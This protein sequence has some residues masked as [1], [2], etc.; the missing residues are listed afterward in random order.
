MFVDSFRYTAV[1]R[2]PLSCSSCSIATPYD[3]KWG[4]STDLRNFSE[5]FLTDS[6]DD[7]FMSAGRIRELDGLRAVAIALVVAYHFDLHV[8]GGFLGVDLFFVVSG[9]VITR[10][11]LDSMRALNTGGAS[12]GG[13][14][15]R[16]L[17]KT[18]YVRRAWRLLPSLVIMLM[19]VTCA[20][21][22][23]GHGIDVRHT[24]DTALASL[25][26]GANWWIG[27]TATVHGV[28]PLT[29]T[30]SLA[31][32]EQLYLVLPM[33]LVIGRRRPRRAA[34]GLSLSLMGLSA[35]WFATTKLDPQSLNRAY[36]SSIARATPVAL[37]IALA[38]WHDRRQRPLA[39]SP[40]ILSAGWCACAA[41]TL[42]ALAQA[43]FD[44]TW[45]YQGGF[46]LMSFALAGLVALTVELAHSN[47]VIA[48]ILRS[49]PATFIGDRSYVLYLV[50][51]PLVFWFGSYGRIGSL[52]LRLVVAAV[53]SEALH[54]LVE[55]PL[56]LRGPHLRR[57]SFIASA[58]LIG[59]ALAVGA[60]LR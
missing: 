56:R 35:L 2:T 47:T 45:L 26:G 37:G 39:V 57:A 6:A 18:F 7:P 3:K 15:V 27:A 46:E 13:N 4:V 50:H 33:V 9:Y 29:H 5:R 42:P 22:V 58:Q 10:G 51:F 32:E 34:L 44:T 54:R 59:A 11:L 30:W 28:G 19:A 41:V 24:V 48:K 60:L 12:V 53:A 43:D 31:I 21:A 17:L 25:S 8:R 36:F 52:A 38:V 20:A 1:I 40:R 55:Q 23:T 49:R 16:S 14:P